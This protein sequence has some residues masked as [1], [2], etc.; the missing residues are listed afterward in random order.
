[1]GWADGVSIVEQGTQMAACTVE[2]TVDLPLDVEHGDVLYRD[3]NQSIQAVTAKFA[4]YSKEYFVSDHG[5]RAAVVVA[6]DRRILVVR[7]YRL[8]INALSR[9]IPGGRIDEGELPSAAAVRECYEETGVLCSDL[10]PLISFQPSLDIWRN[11]THVFYSNR[12]IEE[13]SDHAERREWIDHECIL[14]MVLGGQ[15]C[16]GMSVTALL[17]YWAKERG[18][19][20]NG[21]LLC[22]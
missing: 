17:A 16:D 2:E 4:G 8:L 13:V 3:R 20:E 14:D 7:Q 5:E 12:V 11:P 22:G 18:R 19:E 6:R 15:I 1:M 10:Q 21:G 9:E